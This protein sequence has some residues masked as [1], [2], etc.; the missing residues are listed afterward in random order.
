VVKRTNLRPYSST[1]RGGKGKKH[2]KGKGRRAKKGQ[3]EGSKRGFV[4]R[5]HNRDREFVSPG[6]KDFAQKGRPRSQQKTGQE[7][8]RRDGE[9]FAFMGNQP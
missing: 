6:M 1:C 9:S 3:S 5:G 7:R 4:T 2:E 8:G